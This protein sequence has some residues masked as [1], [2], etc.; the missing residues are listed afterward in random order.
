MSQVGFLI[1]KPIFM[2]IIESHSSVTSITPVVKFAKNTSTV[3]TFLQV[4]KKTKKQDCNKSKYFSC[5]R[6]KLKSGIS[7]IF[8]F[9]TISYMYLFT[10]FFFVNCKSFLR[11]KTDISGSNLK[12]GSTAS[13]EIKN[14]QLY[15]SEKQGSN[16]VFWLLFD[17]RR[18][19]RGDTL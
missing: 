14:D 7:G 18:L 2:V 6:L 11:L 1:M 4:K 16:P 19:E 5:W 3:F 15:V 17:Y 9:L 10:L 8:T 12:V 13:L